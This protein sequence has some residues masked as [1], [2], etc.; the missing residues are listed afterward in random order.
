MRPTSS[1]SRAEAPADAPRVG[2]DSSIGNELDAWSSRPSWPIQAQPSEA[3][4][5]RACVA[6]PCRS[7][8]CPSAPCLRCRSLPILDE[9]RVAPPAPCLHAIALHALPRHACQAR[10]S[11][12][13]TILAVRLRAEPAVPFVSLSCAPDLSLPDAPLPSSRC[14]SILAEPALSIRAMPIRTMLEQTLPAV[15]P[16]RVFTLRPLVGWCVRATSVQS[17]PRLACHA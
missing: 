9:P 15:S 4:S 16:R 6:T 3:W 5:I 17:K 7:T 14:P 12:C 11:P 1:A 10:P 2:S 13:S 8:P